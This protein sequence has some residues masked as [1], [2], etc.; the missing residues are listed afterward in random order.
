MLPEQ[1]STNTIS[2]G[3]TYASTYYGAAWNEPWEQPG[4]LAYIVY[5]GDDKAYKVDLAA[6][7]PTAV[8]VVTLPAGSYYH[9]R[10]VEEAQLVSWKIS[11]TGRNFHLNF[12]AAN[13][14]NFY[15]LAPSVAGY[16]PT[17]I[18]LPPNGLEL[19]LW[20]DLF[21]FM[22]VTGTLGYASQGTLS[23]SGEADVKVD[24]GVTVGLN[25]LWAA[26][27]YDAKGVQDISNLIMVD[28]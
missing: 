12:G 5:N 13:G 25:V 24:F 7:P 22:G 3:I 19:W 4:R 18:T 2:L 10:E 11:N 9:G 14:G 17:A 16:S 21:T 8:S 20:P 23:R 6:T 27:A 1:S 26:V 15:V 28:M